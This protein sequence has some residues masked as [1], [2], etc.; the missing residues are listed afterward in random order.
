MIT[1]LA[2]VGKT[3]SGKDTI[4]RYL[5]ERYDIPC[6]VSHTDR[7]MRTGEKNGR[8]HWFVT[9]EEMDAIVADKDNLLAYTQ[10][11]QTGYRYCATTASLDICGWFTYIIN[12]DG[13]AWMEEHRQDIYVIP[14]YVDLDEDTI[15]ERARLRGDNAEA[16]EA[17]LNSEREQFDSYKENQTWDYCIRTNRSVSEVMEDVDVIIKQLQGVLFRST[18]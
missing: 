14:I 5:K 18:V 17:R 6:V 2:L 7:P 13:I 16:V 3:S 10:F 15:R 1:I 12:P 9:P 8:E 4:A 11:P